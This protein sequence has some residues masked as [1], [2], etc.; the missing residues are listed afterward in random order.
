MRNI[1]D[2]Y[3][4]LGQPVQDA[5]T[6]EP[7]MES[8]E[9][10][11]TEA[12]VADEVVPPVAEDE[13]DPEYDE[14]VPKKL[15]G[16]QRAKLKNQRLEQELQ[17]LKAQLAG[18]STDSEVYETE[19]ERIVDQRLA[20]KERQREAERA[21][22]AWKQK[23]SDG[24]KKYGEAF[25]EALEMAPPVSPDIFDVLIESPVGSDLAYFLATHPEE[26]AKI[27]AMRPA[28]AIRE[29]GRLEAKF[30]AKETKPKP[31][32]KAPAAITP[33]TSVKTA[34]TPVAY[35]DGYLA[36]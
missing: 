36:Y 6:P 13:N 14:I 19:L 34:T 18:Q 32:S 27:N 7:A 3:I 23:I 10:E 20:E 9:P 8:P 26:H 30:E 29:L 16:A 33:Q 31:V 1:E 28:L 2:D 21:Q 22:T 24:Q 17:Q 12:P 4:S 15:T 35:E 11:V 5:G 25:T